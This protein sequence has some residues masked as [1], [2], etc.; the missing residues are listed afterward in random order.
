MKNTERDKKIK[1]RGTQSIQRAISLIR[2][3]AEMDENGVNLSRLASAVDLHPSTTYRILQLLLAENFVVY[4][5]ET[6]QYHLGIEFHRLGRST[7]SNALRERFRSLIEKAAEFSEDTAFLLI[8][9]YNEAV[10]VDRLEGKYPISTRTF[11][12]GSRRL[13]GVGGGA[14]AILS[15]LP[16]KDQEAMIKV[17]EPIYPRF[18]NMSAE[19]V[20]MAVKETRMR[21]YAYTQGNLYSGANSVGVPVT[22]LK[23]DLHA[24]ITVAAVAQRL[25]LERAREVVNY[26]KSEILAAGLF[27][28]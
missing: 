1:L 23:E 5:P 3:V 7:Y 24:A 28:P 12:I 8:R 11:D 15:F 10:C 2:K 14:L 27:T 18:N 17:N 9:A 20:R 19:R 25:D 13:L 26:V 22:D 6:K 16:E 4:N 21:G